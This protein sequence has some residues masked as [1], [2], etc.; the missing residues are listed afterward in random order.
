[1]RLGFH[2]GFGGDAALLAALEVSAALGVSLALAVAEGIVEDA[3]SAGA[4]AVSGD[5]LSHR[6]TATISAAAGTTNVKNTSR[7]CRRCIDSSREGGR[8]SRSCR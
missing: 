7:S 8:F 4:R 1:M 2:A 3:G 6:G 5:R